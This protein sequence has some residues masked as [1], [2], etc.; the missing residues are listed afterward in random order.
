MG[1]SASKSGGGLPNHR[2]PPSEMIPQTSRIDSPWFCKS[3]WQKVD[4]MVKC[5]DHYLCRACLNLLLSVSER[6]PLC[7]YP[8]PTR[9]SLA[10]VPSAPPPPPYTEH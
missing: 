9:V 2:Q 7:K 8:L 4:S 1:Q 3:C 10:A 5:H 6:C